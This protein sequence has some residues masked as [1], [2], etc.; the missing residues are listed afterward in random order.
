MQ[1]LFTNGCSY[2]KPRTVPPHNVTVTVGGEVAKHFNLKHINF[3][4]GGR[5]NDRM[6]L[7]T[8][9]YFIQNPDRIKDTFALIQLSSAGRIDYPTKKPQG[10]EDA[11][12]GQDSAYRAI[13][14]FKDNGQ[15]FLQQNFSKLDQIQFLIQRY[16]SSLMNLQN[17][18]KL[19]KINY[20]FYNGLENY[21]TT[22]KKDHDNLDS[23]IDKKR[24]FAWN[25]EKLVH[26]NFCVDNKLE[27]ENDGHASEQ[28]VI[29]YSNLL[30]DYI[31]THS[32]IL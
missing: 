29:Q 25:D 9:L 8:A 21:T 18:F 10:P 23:Y 32:L 7:T 31:D 20:L 14:I 5:G 22:G 11:M 16:Y 13:N 24:F 26:Y 15:R 12:Q 17:F 28:G 2:S 3:A 1:Y 4:Q 27:L 30:I 19:H 6:F